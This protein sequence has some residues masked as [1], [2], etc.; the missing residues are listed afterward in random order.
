MTTSG[1]MG[2]DMALALYLATAAALLWIWKRFVPLSRAAAL[3][4]VLLPMVFTGKAL[5]T[6]RV[7][8]PIDLPFQYEPLVSR[9]AALG[10]DK[11]HEIALSDL[12]IQIIPWQKAVRYAL[13]RGEWPLWNPFIVCG[14]VL[15]AAAQPAV[16]DPFTLIALLVPLP[17]ALTF[18]ATLTFFLAALFTFSFA[19][20]LGCS[21]TA[22]IVSAA[23]YAFCGMMAFYVGWPLARTWA[24]L[25]LVLFAVRLL[26]NERRT[27]LLIV[28]LTLAIFAGHPESVLHVVAVGAVYGL[29]E[30][31]R[32]RNGKVFF[33]ALAAGLTALA[34]GAIYLLPFFE[35]APQTIHHLVREQFY[36]PTPYSALVPAKVRTER[37]ERTFLSFARDQDPLSARVGSLIL[38]LALS[39]VLLAW[40][41]SEVWFLFGLALVGVLVACGIPPLPNL[42]HGLPVF[43]LAINERLAFAGA[44]A[45]ALLAGIAVDAWQRR[46]SL[47]VLVTGAALGAAMLVTDVPQQRMAELMPLLL[48]VLTPRRFV[49]PVVLALVLLQRSFEDGSIYPSLSKEAF[50]PKVAVLEGIPREGLFRVTGIG[51]ALIPNVGTMYGLEDVRGYNAMTFKRLADTWTMWARPQG[52]WWASVDDPSRPFLSMINVRYILDGN[53]LIENPAVLPRAFVPRVIRYEREEAPVLEAMSKTTDFAE[54]AW[55]ETTL[56]NPHEVSNGP[57]TVAI[58]RDGLAYELE[59]VMEQDGWVVISESAWTGWRAYVDDRRVDLQYANH[60]FLGVYMPA[61]KHRLR[62]VYLPQSFTRGR[63]ISGSALLLCGAA[64]WY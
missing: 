43:D 63:A 60:A 15:A 25:P 22:S 64:A 40:R 49:A 13:A 57:G 38:A 3:V 33:R 39:A 45:M 30:M 34:L 26:V 10:V 11:P 2:S 7:Y 53:R 12:A 6:N 58:R 24:L 29:F 20:A 48:L 47:V 16:Y 5:L 31:V 17:D 37:I 27:P 23:G 36:A 59:S 56:Y 14:D 55:I 28:A 62:L 51:T 8:A 35:A 1:G 50:Y 19:R 42:L 41:R 61:G 4:L 52:P 32:C 44:L 54:R 9:A 21:E 18:G 46:A